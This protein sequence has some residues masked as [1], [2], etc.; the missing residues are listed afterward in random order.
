V[1]CDVAATASA[2]RAEWKKNTK[3]CE[4]MFCLGRG[5]DGKGGRR[6]KDGKA[7]EG[8]SPLMSVSAL[9]NLGWMRAP[10]R[11]A[12]NACADSSGIM[13]FLQAAVQI[14]CDIRQQQTAACNNTSHLKL[15]ENASSSSVGFV[16]VNMSTRR[17]RMR[18]TA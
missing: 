9:E 12:S 11:V 2:E 10:W 1:G 5:V 7:K 13:A 3:E 15:R 14:H 4:E 6:K 16:E 8:H 17:M 18:N